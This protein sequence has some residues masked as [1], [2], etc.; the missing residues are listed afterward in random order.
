MKGRKGSP[1][2]EYYMKGFEAMAKSDTGLVQELNGI[3]ASQKAI[4]DNVLEENTALKKYVEELEAENEQLKRGTLAT[5]TTNNFYI[6]V[7]PFHQVPTTELPPI[8]E[9]KPLLS[10][11]MHSIPE[12]L[13]LKLKNERRII[14]D[15]T[16]MYS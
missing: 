13:K 5:S 10:R 12:L 4:D 1:P 8:S 16:H 15:C 9:V 2:C 11:P 6:N 7:F 14:S 3:V